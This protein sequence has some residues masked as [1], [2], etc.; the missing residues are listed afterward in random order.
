MRQGHG[1]IFNTF[2]HHIQVQCF[3]QLQGRTEDSLARR[4]VENVFQE[5]AIYLEL[6][7]FKARQCAQ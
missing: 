4:V 6:I 5:T 7:Q 1:L 3:T 2:N